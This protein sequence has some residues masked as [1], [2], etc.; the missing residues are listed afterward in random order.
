M[1]F[2]KFLLQN[3]AN[4]GMLV[5]SIIAFS[6]ADIMRRENNKNPTFLDT[7]RNDDAPLVQRKKVEN[8]KTQS[9]IVLL[10]ESNSTK[11]H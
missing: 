4:F 5:L 3:K 1:S 9:N 7:M 10:E 8:R 2:T 11:N 6:A